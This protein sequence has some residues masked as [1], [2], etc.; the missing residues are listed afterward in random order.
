MEK[1]NVVYVHNGYYSPIK[2]NR[3][4]SFV[5]KWMELDIITLSENSHTQEDKHH[6]FSL[7]YRI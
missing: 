4:M 2:K 7:M 6:T 5:G 1:A 3:S